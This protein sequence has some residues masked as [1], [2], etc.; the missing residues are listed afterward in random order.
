MAASFS[1]F[2]R[3]II[4]ER[5]GLNLFE[6]DWRCVQLAQAFIVVIVGASKTNYSDKFSAAHF[7]L[8][9]TSRNAL[10]RSHGGGCKLSA[11]GVNDVAA[12]DHFACSVQFK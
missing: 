10:S 6:S 2:D 12:R 8:L 5:L 3:R 9:A 1:S 4:Y 11:P 7:R